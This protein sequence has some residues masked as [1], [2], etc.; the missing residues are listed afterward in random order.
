MRRRG[1]RETRDADEQLYGGL[2]AAWG[3]HQSGGM[4]MR[5]VA[6]AYAYAYACMRYEYSVKHKLQKL[7]L[8]QQLTVAASANHRKG[9]KKYVRRRSGTV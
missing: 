7:F 1:C 4:C 5:D 8:P 3:G 6:Y 9:Q 2:S